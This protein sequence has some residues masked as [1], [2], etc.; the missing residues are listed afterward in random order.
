M[1]KELYVVFDGPPSL[2]GSRFVGV[3]DVQGRSVTAGLWS[4]DKE[5]GYWRLGPFQ[6]ASSNTTPKIERRPFEWRDARGIPLDAE[7]GKVD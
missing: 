3:E 6:E 7:Q 5:T 4:E 2:E 1:T